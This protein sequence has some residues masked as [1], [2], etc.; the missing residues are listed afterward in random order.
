MNAKLLLLIL[1][2]VV[3]SSSL[4]AQSDY[5]E[6]YNIFL[7]GPE[8]LDV[9]HNIQAEYYLE[10]YSTLLEEIMTDRNDFEQTLQSLEKKIF[11]N[12]KNKK[13]IEELG[14]EIDLI[15][16]EI[17]TVNRYLDLWTSQNATFSNQSFLESL[18][19][20]TCYQIEGRNLTYFP[21]DYRL[22]TLG[23]GS[24]LTGREIRVKTFEKVACY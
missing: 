2:L 24:H 8:N 4:Y 3:G 22:D 12:K 10:K 19:P 6:S 14:A 23:I 11:D 15:S 17:N 20:E 5:L 16:A 9:S 21:D 1:S 18:Q 7:I 13:Q